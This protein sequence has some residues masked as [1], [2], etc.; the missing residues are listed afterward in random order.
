MKK[1]V[2]IALLAVAGFAFMNLDCV[3]PT[4]E[5]RN[6]SYEPLEEGAKAKITWD[7][8]AEGTPDEYVVSVDGVDQVAVTTTYDMVNIP[9]KEIKVYAVTSGTKSTGVTLDFAV[10]ETPTLDVWTVN[11]PSATHPSGFGFSAAGTAASYSVAN[12]P[13]NCDFYISMGQSGNT[14]TLTSPSDHTPNPLNS[15]YGWS[16]Q[17][18]EDYAGLDLVVSSATSTQ[19]A[20]SNNGTYGIIVGTG[21]AY[22]TTDNFGKVYVTALA[23]QGSNIY[24]ATLKLGYQLKDGIAWVME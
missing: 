9:A 2:A 17:T 18:T 21:T 3:I 15:R 23:D 16:V 22:A 11:D 5:V 8:P 12:N 6:L 14:P 4:G 24:K 7:A 13:E 19:T 10:V 20:L 1:F